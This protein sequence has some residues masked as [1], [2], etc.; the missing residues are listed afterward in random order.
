MSSDIKILQNLSRPGFAD[1]QDY[2][3]EEQGHGPYS[4]VAPKF[5]LCRSPSERKSD[6]EKGAEYLSDTLFYRDTAVQALNGFELEGGKIDSVEISLNL[7]KLVKRMQDAGVTGENIQKL[8]KHSLQFNSDLVWHVEQMEK[9]GK[10]ETVEGLIDY[11]IRTRRFLPKT[12]VVTKSDLN[13][14]ANLSNPEFAKNNLILGSKKAGKITLFKPGIEDRITAG[15]KPEVLDNALKLAAQELADR[16]ERL[17]GDIFKMN[18]TALY[19]EWGVYMDPQ[20]IKLNLARL[21]QKM[22]QMATTAETKKAIAELVG[23]TKV[24]STNIRGEVTRE[25][26]HGVATNALKRKH[27]IMARLAVVPDNHSSRKGKKGILEQLLRLNPFTFSKTKFKQLIS[28]KLDPNDVKKIETTMEIIADQADAKAKKLFPHDEDASVRNLMIEILF[29]R[30]AVNAGLMTHN[31][32]FIK[33]I[34]KMLDTLL[35]NFALARFPTSVRS[36]VAYKKLVMEE[37]APLF[38]SL[39]R[40]IYRNFLRPLIGR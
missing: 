29:A 32:P 38:P 21:G 35:N 13:L 25:I 3:G 20:T 30:G 17:K 37:A 26:V 6:L 36:Q 39:G 7:L 28:D 16:M 27:P 10:K 24:T 11:V 31:D 22:I 40:R 19:S 5:Q 1:N 9:V 14:L 8:I 4:R 34:K 33:S 23:T 12:P 2:I 15:Q 18:G